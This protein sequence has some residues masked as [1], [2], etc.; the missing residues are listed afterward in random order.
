VS[1]LPPEAL[2]AADA[3]IKSG[4]FSDRAEYAKVYFREQGQKVD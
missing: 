1:R 2:K 4:L 3:D